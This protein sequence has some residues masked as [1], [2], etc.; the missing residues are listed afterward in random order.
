MV[1]LRIS[2]LGKAIC[3]QSPVAACETLKRRRYLSESALQDPDGVVE[4]L[5]RI[6]DAWPAEPQPGRE[7]WRDMQTALEE[8]GLLSRAGL[9]AADKYV[10]RRSLFR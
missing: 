6:E 4:L 2:K 3:G 8:R 7:R 1:S 10:S 9:S 5:Q